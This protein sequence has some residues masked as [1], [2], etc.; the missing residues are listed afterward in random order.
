MKEGIKVE[1][2]TGDNSNDAYRLY[3]EILREMRMVRNR[4]LVSEAHYC[5]S[6]IQIDP[7]LSETK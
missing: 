4:E 5:A 7:L 3:I 6:L 2:L 1:V